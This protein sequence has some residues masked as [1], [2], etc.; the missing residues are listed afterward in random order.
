M[1]G[2]CYGPTGSSGQGRLLATVD[3]DLPLGGCGRRSGWFFILP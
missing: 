3:L 2:G 1:D